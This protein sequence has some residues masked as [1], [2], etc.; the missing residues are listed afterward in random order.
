MECSV[1]RFIETCRDAHD[2]DSFHFLRK[3]LILR[4]TVGN[5]LLNGRV[6]VSRGGSREYG[7]SLGNLP[8]KPPSLKDMVSLGRFD[9]GLRLTKLRSRHRSFQT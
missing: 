1:Y 7:G 8:P 9:A 3:T 5:L 2:H 6:S 4:S